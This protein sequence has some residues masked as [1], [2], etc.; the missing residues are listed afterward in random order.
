MSLQIADAAAKS[1]FDTRNHVALLDLIWSVRRIAFSHGVGKPIGQRPP[2]HPIYPD[3][4]RP[5]GS[6]DNTERPRKR[7][8]ETDA[9]LCG[10]PSNP[11]DLEAEDVLNVSKPEKRQKLEAADRRLRK[12]TSAP[13]TVNPTN[14]AMFEKQNYLPHRLAALGSSKVLV[15]GELHRI[16]AFSQERDTFTQLRRVSRTLQENINATIECQRVMKNMYEADEQVRNA[17][18]FPTLLRLRDD[19]QESEKGAEK[20][21]GDV[22]EIIDYLTGG[23]GMIE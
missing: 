22:A 11:I 14:F 3:R 12:V 20:G 13:Q 21:L 1:G 8:R 10:T 16:P 17:S 2:K 23:I 15:Q 6:G 19:M 5:S 9:I 18:I 7:L 4:Y